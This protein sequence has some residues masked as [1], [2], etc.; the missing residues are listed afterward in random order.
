MGWDEEIAALNGMF[1]LD[2]DEEFIA[3]I[4]GTVS[5]GDIDGREGILFFTNFRLGVS[6]AAGFFTEDAAY[7]IGHVA[8]INVETDDSMQQ[9][10]VN[11]V[12]GP[13]SIMWAEDQNWQA[14]AGTLMAYANNLVRADLQD[15]FQRAESLAEGGRFAEAVRALDGLLEYQP[16]CCPALYIKSDC[17]EAL[18][19]FSGAAQALAQALEAGSHIAGILQ[20]EIGRLHIRMEDPSKAVEHT[21]IAI[22]QYDNFGAYVWRATAQFQLEQNN[23]AAADLRQAMRHDRDSASVWNTVGEY[24]L[25]RDDLSE[26]KKAIRELKRL[27]F[28]EAAESLRVGELRMEDKEDEAVDLAV[29][30]LKKNPQDHIVVDQMMRSAGG[31]NIPKIKSILP[32]LDK[33]YDDTFLYQFMTC[34]ISIFTGDFATARQR[35]HKAHALLDDAQARERF[36]PVEATIGAE[37]ALRQGNATRAEQLTRPLET[38]E[39]WVDKY[40]ALDFL[41]PYVSFLRGRALL[42][43]DRAA[44]ARRFLTVAGEVPEDDCW[45]TKAEIE[46]LQRQA[47]AAAAPKTPKPKAPAGSVGETGPQLETLNVLG[48]LVERLAGA[49]QMEDLGHEARE[50]QAG[51][52][53]PPLIAVMGE[54]SVGKSTFINAFLG[55]EL[56]PSGE[57]VTTGAI[58][59]L[60]YGEQERMRISMFDGTVRDF[61][62]LSSID[63]AVR[64][65]G[66]EDDFI[67]KVRHVELFLEVPVLRKINI[68]DSP[69]LNAPFPEHLALTEGYLTESDAILFL[70][71]V[72]A[73][74]R[75]TE[76]A[77]LAKLEE[78]RRKA[79]GVVN[80]IDLVLP[81][82]AEEVVEDVGND[83]STY[84]SRVLGVSSLLAL[85]GQRDGNEKRIKKSR[86]PKLQS[87]LDTNLLQ[88]ARQVK[89]TA[90]DQKLREML[91]KVP[92][93]RADL[94]KRSKAAQDLIEEEGKRAQQWLSGRLSPELDD[95]RLALENRI[96]G[97]I[98]AVASKLV[99]ITHADGTPELGRANAIGREF[100]RGLNDAISSVFDPAVKELDTFLASLEENLGRV[101]GEEWA[102][103]QERAHSE[104][105]L[106]QQ[107]WHKGIGYNLERVRGFAEGFI[108]ARGIWS[109]MYLEVPQGQRNHTRTVSKHLKSRFSTIYSQLET[110]LQ[111]WKAK[112]TEELGQHLGNRN[113]AI[114]RET[115]KQLDEVYRPVE[116]IASSLE[117][118]LTLDGDDRPASKSG[119]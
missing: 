44:E 64:E 105:E 108:E 78:H 115:A 55:R 34:A 114:R 11:T 99:A 33:H 109:T 28:H 47:L 39:V 65:T 13:F 79:I 72:E 83:F 93:R 102:Q 75:S 3:A 73:A 24:A 61:D 82:E 104:L 89:R 56:L 22:E 107:S 20:S 92:T 88:Q 60:R 23:A 74:G 66:G 4:E 41:R 103:I 71:N 6:A 40:E 45:W 76:A 86:M 94:E 2:E 10:T 97:D 90:T 43:L 117:D 101:E 42:E 68:V 15:R 14:H 19:D 63:D 9:I 36:L 37:G 98:E 118:R 116:V 12:D 110:A 27:E 51:Y 84:F 69:G 91:D 106:L 35:M 32:D 77:F 81:E 52:D 95:A 113:I 100:L 8:T 48:R 70:F 112:L 16:W 46:A 38:A 18:D 53:D 96:D 21:T 29:R 85:K 57:G 17:L 31:S 80:Q 26:L 50:L 67:R 58:T 7:W 54:Y 1:Q 5:A 59:L 49:Q 119:G 111:S 87:W 62:G 30:L 25:D